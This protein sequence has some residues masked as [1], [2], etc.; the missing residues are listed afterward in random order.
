MTKTIVHKAGTRGH[1]DHGWLNAHHSF[2]FAGYHDPERVHFGML[3]VLND[4]IVSQG[5]GFG[6][7]PH[8]NMEI[9]TI[10]LEGALE[11]KDSMGHTQA[12][13]PNEVQ[14]MS[15]GTGVFHSEYNHN[16]DKKVNLLQLWI[17]PDKRNVEPRYD[18]KVF[19]AEER[20]NKLQTL[21]SSIDGNDE[22]L[23]IHQDARIYR[24]TLEEGKSLSHV[25]KGDHHGVYA[26]VIE[27]SVNI[28]GEDLDK[29]DAM[30]ISG[31]EQLDI[32]ALANTDVLLVEVPMTA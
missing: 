25:I 5:M 2:S 1:A 21:V 16:R 9:I 6:K 8:D 3:R 13:H 32:K 11:H 12:I 19:A 22:G 4:D 18:Q 24:T 26:F 28:N 20:V 30:G 15:A 27:G 14:V 17:F 31:A 10:I 7:H 23:K 29:R